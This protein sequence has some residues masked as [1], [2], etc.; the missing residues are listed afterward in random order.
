MGGIE[1]VPQNNEMNSL[2]RYL[3]T[4]LNPQDVVGFPQGMED[5]A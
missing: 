3:K 5:V 2:I 4:K 1:Y